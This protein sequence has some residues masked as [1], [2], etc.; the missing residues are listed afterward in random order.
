MFLRLLGKS[1]W[2]T[3]HIWER[4]SDTAFFQPM[5]TELEW[6]QRNRRKRTDGG[7]SSNKTR[8][9]RNSDNKAYC[10]TVRRFGKHC[11]EALWLDYLCNKCAAQIRLSCFALILYQ[12]GCPQCDTTGVSANPNRQYSTACEWDTTILQNHTNINHLLITI[13]CPHCL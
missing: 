11:C 5:E 6:A 4:N 10:D 7:T 9:R 8:V 3:D 2:N 13:H 1:Q 12:S